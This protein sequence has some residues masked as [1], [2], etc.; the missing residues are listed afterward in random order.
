MIMGGSL[1][2]MG[3]LL[4]IIASVFFCF[5]HPCRLGRG[6]AQKVPVLTLK[7]LLSPEQI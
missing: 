2:I 7:V 3:G 4:M 5:L 1:M 6:C